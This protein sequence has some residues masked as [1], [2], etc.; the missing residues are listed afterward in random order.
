MGLV[1][2]GLNGRRFRITTPLPQDFRDRFLEGVREFAFQP[3]PDAADKEPTVG[4]VDIFEPANTRFELNTFLF[5]RYLALALRVDK[6]SV[7]G[8]Y[9]KIAL[10]EREHQVME[11]RGL[12]KLSKTE[13]QAIKEAVEA[14]LYARALP[15]VSTIDVVWDIHT[16]EVI[17]F[18]TSDSQ[19]EL[20]VEN[21][22]A[23]FDVRLRPERMADWLH[24][25]L[26][27]DEIIE[28]TERFLPGARGSK[29]TA[30]EVDG[31]RM[32]D[33]LENVEFFLASDFITWLWLQSEASDGRFRVIEGEDVRTAVDEVA[34]EWNDVTAS[35]E[36]AD[37]TL[38]LENKLKLQ[39]VE[40]S[41]DLPETT[42]LLGAAPTTSE[43]ARRDLH[44]G[45]RPVEAALGMKIEELE[46]A[47]ALSA[48]EGGLVVSGLKLPF[49]VKK[50]TDEKIFE[51]MMLLDL[52]HSTLKQLFV[53]FFLAR[54][55][56][57]WEERVSA[58][59][60]Q[61]PLAAK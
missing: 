7:N 56:P 30:G 18:G 5:D 42:I 15:S 19:V 24:E 52:V 58:W 60:A 22:E 27:W 1:Q 20:V 3:R 21:F 55:S 53:Q 25:R 40:A 45:K 9:A 33:P 49:E 46:I 59:I 17:V 13:R 34:D 26:S 36:R 32:D 43:H 14:E 44:R 50:G 4:W 11:E 2:G 54:T 29:G 37:L 12:E 51:R 10:Y 39:Q 48:R 35:L 23:T 38:W 41:D 57:A 28:R 6:K 31:Y 47:M 61:E 8:R 16:G